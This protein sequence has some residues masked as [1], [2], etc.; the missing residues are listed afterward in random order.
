MKFVGM[1]EERIGSDD[2]SLLKT[3]QRNS[4][5]VGTSF[6]MQTVRL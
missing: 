2:D 1:D 3:E 5:T 6:V 4:G